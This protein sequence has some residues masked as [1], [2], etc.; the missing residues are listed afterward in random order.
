MVELLEETRANMEYIESK[1]YKVLEIWEC[2]WRELKKT[3][4]ELQRF[5]ATEVR[6]TLDKVKIMSPERILSKVRNE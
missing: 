5:I 1:G 6:R 3:D 4:R 2:E